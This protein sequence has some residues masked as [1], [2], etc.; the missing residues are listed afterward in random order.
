MCVMSLAT[1]ILLAA[2]PE[3]G[4]VLD[5]FM[6]SGTT[7]V[8]AARNRRQFI[9]FD[10]SPEYVDIANERVEKEFYKD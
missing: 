4:T 9:G 3:G 5:P 2:C 10:I 8:V 7:A 6:G 1:R